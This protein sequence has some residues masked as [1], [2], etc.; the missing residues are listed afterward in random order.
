MKKEEIKQ[1]ILRLM[2]QEV[3]Q[4][5]EIQDKIEDGY[6]Y[7][8]KFLEASRKMSALLL[9]R[10]M[11]KIPGSRNQKKKFIPVSDESK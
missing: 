9:T 6:E 5:L 8:E 7:E 11:G 1:N 2:S 4:W 3:D 10:S